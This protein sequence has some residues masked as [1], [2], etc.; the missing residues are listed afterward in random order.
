MLLDG[1]YDLCHVVPRAA[2][3]TSTGASSGPSTRCCR[4]FSL[5]GPSYRLS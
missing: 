4:V 3:S 1:R 5:T 2:P